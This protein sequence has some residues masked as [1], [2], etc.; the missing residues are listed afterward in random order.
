MV[1]KRVIGRK[2]DKHKTCLNCERPIE[3][4]LRDDYEYRCRHCGQD[5]F[6]D[7]YEKNIVLTRA[8]YPQIRKRHSGNETEMQQQRNLEEFVRKVEALR[9]EDQQNIEK[10]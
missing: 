7:I 1:I 9:R 4:R 6:V 10:D 8:E 5:H 2:S 3:M